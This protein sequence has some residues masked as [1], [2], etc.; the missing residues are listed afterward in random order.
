MPRV[1]EK[2]RKYSKIF[3]SKKIL[4]GAFL[5]DLFVILFPKSTEA[6][7]GS[8]WLWKKA[9]GSWLPKVWGLDF[10][11]TAGTNLLN[12]ILSAVG[13]LLVTL[14]SPFLTLSQSLLKWVTS[15]SFISVGYL[16][17]NNEI[18]A[19]GWTRMRN[20]ANMFFVVGLVVIALAT[21]LRYKEYQAQKL[22]PKLLIIA[23]LINFIPVIAGTVIDAS[24]IVMDHFL[25]K[26]QLDQGMVSN[27]TGRINDIS[28]DIKQDDLTQ[29]LSRVVM[30]VAFELVITM[31]YFLYAFL[32]AIR[33]IALWLLII[34]SPLAFLAY[35]FPDTKQWW[36]QW[37]DQFLQWCFV[38]IAGAFFLYLAHLTMPTSLS[39][40]GVTLTGDPSGSGAAKTSFDY[41]TKYL[42]PIIFMY[43]GFILAQK[44]GAMGADATIKASKTVG[45]WGMG[46][47]GKGTKKGL[48]ATGAPD[49]LRNRLEKMR[50]SKEPE[51]EDRENMNTKDK[52]KSAVGSALAPHAMRRAIGRA[53]TRQ[54]NTPSQQVEELVEEYK[55]TDLGEKKSN[56]M[57]AAN[58]QEKLAMMKAAL[59]DGQLDTWK[60]TGLT[61]DKIKDVL[62]KTGKVAPTETKDLVENTPTIASDVKSVLNKEQ[63]KKAGLARKTDE[64]DNPIYDSITTQVTAEMSTSAIENLSEKTWEEIKKHPESDVA[65][66]TTYWDGRQYSKG[67]QEFGG[68]AA[69]A[70][71][72]A[73]MEKGVR[74][75]SRD[76]LSGYRYFQSN[77]S[78][79]WGLQLPEQ[80]DI[81]V[82]GGR[83]SPGSSNVKFS[84]KDRD[85][86]DE[87]YDQAMNDNVTE[88][89]LKI[90]AR[91]LE[92]G[93]GL[94]DREAKIAEKYEDKIRKMMGNT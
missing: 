71:T 83:S 58:K 70:F 29:H 41:V 1:V 45:K 24:N 91:Q 94:R 48:E 65:K 33:P 73:V 86:P 49:R 77:A 81:D 89:R 55:G 90:I 6:A 85:I 8:M 68:L 21:I 19:L 36:D 52:L 84:S 25:N 37:W 75:F 46:M 7:T 10:L 26:I 15:D 43:A 30:L 22:L 16:P 57:G 74:E 88:K 64:N 27:L 53:G 61:D 54:L 69:D 79:K 13:S 31:V 50:T 23:L 63:E 2:I 9:V 92:K 82:E 11:N 14:I 87:E 72:N 34:L 39:E 78:N 80:K 4:I 3:L 47:V 28:T 32:F 40:M 44:S 42:V 66:G 76:N 56:F 60:K 35:I 51:G 38:G 67:A 59:E 62:T 17:S 12:A 18:V 93:N 20:F 5:V